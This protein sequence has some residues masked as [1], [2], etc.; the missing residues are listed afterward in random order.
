MSLL[1]P[2]D[3]NSKLRRVVRNPL[4][5]VRAKHG[6]TFEAKKP[7]VRRVESGYLRLR[8]YDDIVKGLKKSEFNKEQFLSFYGIDLDD[9]PSLRLV[10]TGTQAQRRILGSSAAIAGLK[11]TV[12][13]IASYLQE[14]Y[15]YGKRRS[16]SPIGG[17]RR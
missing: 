14:V 16:K 10:P 2:L 7:P 17:T 1:N 9:F 11:F 8:V 13:P 3:K 5:K 15:I 12:D 6:R 4:K